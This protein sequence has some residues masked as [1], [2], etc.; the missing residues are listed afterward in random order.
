MWQIRWFSAPRRHLPLSYHSTAWV[1]SFCPLKHKSRG[2]HCDD[3][4]SETGLRSMCYR[5][6]ILPY[7]NLNLCLTM[8]DWQWSVSL[9]RTVSYLE[10]NSNKSTNKNLR[11][12]S[13]LNCGFDIRLCSGYWPC[14]AFFT[15]DVIINWYCSQ[16]CRMNLS[17]I[18]D[19]KIIKIWISV[20]T[21]G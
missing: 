18:M 17:Y 15:S 5:F 21:W 1:R 6:G 10:E 14:N 9:V 2:T 4:I 13:I 20:C 11:S 16:I 7:W 8:Q 12:K 19:R 3:N